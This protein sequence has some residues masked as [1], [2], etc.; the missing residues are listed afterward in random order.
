M[1]FIKGK[2]LLQQPVTHQPQEDSGYDS[3]KTICTEEYPNI[4]E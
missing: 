1:A 4:Y 3:E 2:G